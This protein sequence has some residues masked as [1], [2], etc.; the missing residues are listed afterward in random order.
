MISS[1][2]AVL[3]VQ[4]ARVCGLD[5]LLGKRL[6]PWRLPLAIHDPGKIV[7]DLA[8]RSPW[9]AT[10]LPISRWCGPSRGCSGWWPRIR[11]CRG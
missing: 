10:V 8:W 1:A 4:A 7:L 6:V 3:L 9:A 5:R 2:G 11:R